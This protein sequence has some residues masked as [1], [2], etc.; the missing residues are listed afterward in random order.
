MTTSLSFHYDHRP[1]DLSEVLST[2][3]AASPRFI[4]LFPEKE[5]ATQTKHE[6]LE[7]QVKART[8][9]F[10][11]ATSEGVLT[12]TESEAAKVRPGMNISLKD[13]CAV[14]VVTEKT[15]TT[16]SVAFL[17]SNG[18]ESGSVAD[19]PSSGGIFR[20]ISEPMPEASR[21]GAISFRQSAT[22]W[23]QTQIFRDG[24][25]VSKTAASIGTYGHENAVAYQEQ[26]ALR[27]LSLDINTTALYGVRQQRGPSQNGSLGGLYFFGTMPD[28]IGISLTTPKPLSGVL[29][30]DA[31]QLIKD[32]GG[33]PQVILVG[34]GQARVLSSI[35][36]NKLQ[37]VRA[38]EVRGAYVSQ[39]VN[40]ID[41]ALMRIFV[42]PGL[43]DTDAWVIDPT[44]FGRATLRDI[45]ST[46][47]TSNGSDSF[48]RK[49]IGEFTLQFKNARQRLC[50]IKGLTPSN[51][52][53]ALLES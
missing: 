25:S 1:R 18:S 10:S 9:L 46:D 33:D 37:V 34:T 38:D 31:A 53:L 22:Q 26:N 41:G 49:I 21:E 36:K 52:A 5:R 16:I 8:F 29:V 3:I 17:S 23:N 15:S 12:V 28:G 42:E 20:I 19:L 51:L 6:W 45:E 43:S 39:I 30:N 13:D 7:D 48:D 32:E 47:A 14:F 50:R 40:D 35:Y 24:V 44:G 11:A 27:N 2:V 4:S